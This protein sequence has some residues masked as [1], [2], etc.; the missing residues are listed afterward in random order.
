MEIASLK[1]QNTASTLKTKDKRQII[2][3]Y[4]TKVK[5][6]GLDFNSENIVCCC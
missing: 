2:E 1:L 6:R 3:I 5:L 4:L